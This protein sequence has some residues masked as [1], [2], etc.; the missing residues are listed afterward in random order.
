MKRIFKI[1]LAIIATAAAGGII[2]WQVHKKGIVRDTIETTVEKKTDSLYYIHYDSSSIDEING[3][4]SFYNV[5]L[6]S[7][8]A[9]KKLLE[10]TDSLPNALYRISVAEVTARGVDIP[11]LL[12]NRNIAASEILLIKPQRRSETEGRKGG[13]SGK[14]MF[15]SDPPPPSSK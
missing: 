5:T 11:G 2:Y 14:G 6:Q 9:Q 15:S 12:Q 4:A 10:S 7:D 3:N 13:Y 1:L 8:A